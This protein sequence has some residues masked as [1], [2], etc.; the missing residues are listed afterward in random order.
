MY[1]HQTLHGYQHGHNKVASSIILSPVDEDRMKILSDWS[2]YAGGIDGDMSYITAYPLSQDNLFVVAKTWYADEM[3]RPGCVWTHSLIIDLSEVDETFDFRKLK[4]YFHRPSNDKYSY[5]K[6]IDIN[7]IDINETGVPIRLQDTWLLYNLITQHKTG[8]IFGIENTSE[9]YQDI[10]L[11]I[12]QYLPIGIIKKL[13][14][15]TG[16]SSIRKDGSTEFSMTF[17]SMPLNTLSSMAIKNEN[18]DNQQLGILYICESLCDKNSDIFQLIRLFSKD[19]GINY[20]EINTLGFLLKAL[21]DAFNGVSKLSYDSLLTTIVNIYPTSN[22]AN[23]LK[24]FFFGRKVGLLFTTEENYYVQI[25]TLADDVFDDWQS[26]GI[27]L[28][29]EKYMSSSPERF[30]SLISQLVSLDSMNNEGKKIINIAAKIV[31]EPLLRDLCVNNWSV[32]LALIVTRVELLNGDY[33]LSL[34]IN[35]VAAIFP[36]IEE[37]NVKITYWDKILSYILVNSLDVTS[38]FAHKIYANC[39]KTISLI[40]DFMQKQNCTSIPN[41]IQELCIINNKDIITWMNDQNVLSRNIVHYII[42]IVPPTSKTVK[43]CGVKPWIAFSH[44]D[45]EPTDYIFHTFLFCLSLNWKSAI[46]LEI[47]KKSF[48]CIYIAM[49]KDELPLKEINKLLPYMEE[50]PFWQSWDNCKKLRKGI[51]KAMKRL[52]YTRNDIENF[53]PSNDLNS[54]LLKIWD[55]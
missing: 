54:A 46:S 22:V 50:L 7:A 43:D 1:I 24:Q 53:T 3:S 9:Y 51:V 6:T 30:I 40:M 28:S 39:S 20:T 17:S 4:K 32:Y 27:E 31:S 35:K 52:G 16:S 55:K 33:W 8:L 42:K 44:V 23:T 29:A 5:D 11:S 13:R 14:L 21:S 41:T 37:M 12:L 48:F 10:I 19:I 25:S 2:E 18:E 34:P 26:I 36:L 47:L 15:C 45:A 38:N 49:S